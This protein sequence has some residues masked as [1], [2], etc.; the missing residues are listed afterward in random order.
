MKTA[1]LICLVTLL[2]ISPTAGFCQTTIEWTEDGVAT[3]KFQH[4]GGKYTYHCGQGFEEIYG[5]D[6]YGIYIHYSWIQEIGT[7]LMVWVPG[8]DTLTFW[9]LDDDGDIEIGTGD[10]YKPV[11]AKNLI[12]KSWRAEQL[13]NDANLKYRL[14]RWMVDEILKKPRQEMK[15]KQITCQNKKGE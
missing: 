8:L 1:I 4:Q 5:S 11:D 7:W 10:G 6:K 14:A 3:L 2:L 9:D 12:I 13:A 15:I